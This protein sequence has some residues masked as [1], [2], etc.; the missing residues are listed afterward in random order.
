[1]R[2][3]TESFCGIPPRI[4]NFIARF[5]GPGKRIL[6]VGSSSGLH[7]KNLR[8]QV[9]VLDLDTARLEA[10]GRYPNVEALIRH[11]LGQLP[12]PV[13]K[14]FDMILCLEVLEHLEWKDAVALLDH[15]EGLTTGGIV[16]ST[17]N[18]TNITQL[19]RFF[20]MREL[21]FYGSYTIV[22]KIL[23]RVIH[24]HWF[25]VKKEVAILQSLQNDESILSRHKC[26]FNFSYFRRR[27]YMV[28]GGT[29]IFM[30]QYKLLRMLNT[31]LKITL[32]LL[33]FLSGTI[34]AY[35]MIDNPRHSQGE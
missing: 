2:D 18:V 4:R 22:E 23:Y 1:M 33:Y 31:P 34:W 20:L 6:E 29:S 25:D 7:T 24:G 9:T 8:G 3:D 14:P 27:G 11:D 16:F 5:D 21:P 15:L 10:S 35:K 19:L 13:T 12:L 30:Q 17:P 32:D 26:C 28:T